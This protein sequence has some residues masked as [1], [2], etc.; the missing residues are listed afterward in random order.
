[1]ILEKAPG[2]LYALAVHPDG[3]QLATVTL[4][5]WEVH[6][7]DME[8]GKQTQRIML[9]QRSITG[10][11]Y[12]E[13]GNRLFTTSLDKQLKVCDA[14]GGGLELLTLRC[15]DQEI[16]GLALS[17]NYRYLAS[18]GR[19]GEKAPAFRV[20]STSREFTSTP[21]STW[22]RTTFQVAVADRLGKLLGQRLGRRV[23]VRHGHGPRETGR[24]HR[25][26]PQGRRARRAVRFG[27]IGAHI[28]IAGFS[29]HNQRAG[30]SLFAID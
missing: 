28:A 23:V 9:H 20:K 21:Q 30:R 10:L 6:T 22:A 19:N 27:P 17:P 25:R 4:T 26:V 15:H 16:L 13:S 3:L 14:N 11:A 29:M 5:A 24:G 7:W 1:M 12:S 8:T 2:W 18:V